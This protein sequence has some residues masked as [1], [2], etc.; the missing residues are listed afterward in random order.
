M[1]GSGYCPFQPE[2]PTQF[3]LSLG[4][5]LRTNGLPA[6]ARTLL[7]RHRLA[8]SA[9][10][11]GEMADGPADAAAAAREA[12]LREAALRSSSSQPKTTTSAES[13]G[14]SAGGWSTRDSGS[15]S[16][17]DRGS[18]PSPRDRSRSRSRDRRDRGRDR[19]RDR[20]RG[21][22][23]DSYHRCAR[24]RAGSLRARCHDCL[25][26]RPD[27]PRRTAGTATEIVG[28]TGTEGAIA[29]EGVTAIATGTGGAAENPRWCTRHPTTTT[30]RTPAVCA[31]RMPSATWQP[32]RCRRLRT[33][34]RRRHPRY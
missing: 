31:Q 20:D 8:A 27:S 14:G 4:Y 15:A 17:R 22:D 12:A 7:G 26:R 28:A 33:R 21:R 32:E 2:R 6:A 18:S 23:R 10:Y 1:M 29:T 30:S 19:D 3:S 13:A 34:R 24:S 5:A 9:R 11:R 16:P 25:T